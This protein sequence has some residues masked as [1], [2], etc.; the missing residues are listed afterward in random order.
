MFAMF[1]LLLILNTKIHNSIV[2]CSLQLDVNFAF[3][4]YDLDY[5]VFDSL[6]SGH[7]KRL[8]VLANTGIKSTVCGPESFTPD[9]K[10]IMG[11]LEYILLNRL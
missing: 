7:I 3:G 1:A 9:H 8:P 11:Q 4:L 10:P 2:T 6:M 5:E